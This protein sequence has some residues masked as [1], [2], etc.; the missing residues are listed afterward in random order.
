MTIRSRSLV[1][2]LPELVDAEA[3]ACVVTGISQDS[4]KIVAGDLFCARAG[5]QYKGINFVADAI[6]KGAAA[7]LIDSLEQWAEPSPVP[8]IAVEQLAQR[9]SGIA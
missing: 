1:E 6:E 2:L 7:I 3:G 4:R 8:V 5:G 9:L